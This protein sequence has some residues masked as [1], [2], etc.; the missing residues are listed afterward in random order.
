LSE[1]NYILPNPALIS[2]FIDDDIASKKDKRKAYTII[3][4]TVVSSA[5]LT[6]LQYMF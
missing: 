3:G 4:L 2:G 5:I 1:K 6:A